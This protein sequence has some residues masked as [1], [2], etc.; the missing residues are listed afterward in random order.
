[1]WDYVNEGGFL[2]IDIFLIVSTYGGT[3]SAFKFSSGLWISIY[4]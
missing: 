1:M 4:F 2:P 3:L